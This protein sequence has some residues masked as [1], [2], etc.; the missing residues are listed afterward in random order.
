MSAASRDNEEVVNVL[1][2]HGAPSSAEDGKG[3][4]ALDLA[5]PMVATAM[6]RTGVCE[7]VLYGV[8][9]AIQA[10]CKLEDSAAIAARTSLEEGEMLPSIHYLLLTPCSLL[11]ALCSLLLAPCSLL[12][13]PCSLLLAP[14][15]LL[16]APC[17]LLL[18]THRSPLTAHL[19]PLTSHL[20]RL[21]THDLRLTIHHSPL[22][23]H[24]SPLTTPD[25][26]LTTY[27]LLECNA[28]QEGEMLRAKSVLAQ[29]VGVAMLEAQG[30]HQM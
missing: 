23:T 5:G 17:S 7:D 1:L 20:S 8:R 30:D 2:E 3:M 6:F 15:S 9:K 22:T 18:A 19:S 11:L 24:H 27:D 12:H 14:C 4:T 21:T 10:A 29:R 28:L 13:A 26:R 16:L 25:L